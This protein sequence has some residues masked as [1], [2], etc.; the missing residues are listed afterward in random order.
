MI[1]NRQHHHPK[2]FRRD[3]KSKRERD[4]REVKGSYIKGLWECFPCKEI[5][6]IIAENPWT[7]TPTFKI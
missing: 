7:F 3:R 2:P 1:L 4:E 5:M 6:K